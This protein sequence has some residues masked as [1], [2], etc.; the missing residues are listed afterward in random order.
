MAANFSSGAGEVCSNG[1]GSAPRIEWGGPEAPPSGGFAA[2][3]S[4]GYLRAPT[5]SS[6]NFG[7]VGSTSMSV[8]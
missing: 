6:G 7:G 5:P 2:G 4:S 3:P 1:I 8:P